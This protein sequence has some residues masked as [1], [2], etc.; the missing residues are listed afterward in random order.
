[1]DGWRLVLVNSAHRTIEHGRIGAGL[2][3][4]LSEA[5]RT[6]LSVLIALHH[7]PLSSCGHQ[8]CRLEDGEALMS[9]IDANPHVRLVV[10]GH[11]HDAGD[12]ERGD[13]TYLLGPS[14]CI[15]LVHQHPLQQHNTEATPIGARWLELD[16]DGSF[17]TGLVWV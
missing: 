14:T 5:L 12:A 8:D 16:S 1:V 6:Q 10:S 17:R 15:Q 9:E 4:E 11:L 3:S 2:R 13:T 7:P